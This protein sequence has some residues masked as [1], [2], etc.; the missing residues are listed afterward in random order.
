MVSALI[1]PDCLFVCVFVCSVIYDLN[2]T[3]LIETL[4]HHRPVHS[5]TV[6]SMQPM[7]FQAIKISDVLE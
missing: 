2:V 5:Q 4:L 6:N 1:W 3:E 7:C